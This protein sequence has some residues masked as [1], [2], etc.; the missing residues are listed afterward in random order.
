MSRPLASVV[1]PT[2]DR[3]AVLARTLEALAAQEHAEGLFD[4]V[5]AVNAS[6]DDTLEYLEA[7][8]WPFKLRV[9]VLDRPGAALARNE[10]AR[11][12]VA[13]L[14]IFLDDDIQPCP[15]FVRAHLDAHGTTLPALDASPVVGIGYLPTHLQP[16]Q[17]RFAITLRGWWEAMFDRMREPGHRFSWMD[18]LSGNCSVGRRSFTAV[19]GFETSLRCHEDYELGYRLIE[20][21]CRFVFVEDAA[22]WHADETR[23]ERACRRKREEG[24]ADAWI[25][26]HHPELR[27]GLPMSRPATVRQRLSRWLAFTWPSA[28]DVGARV[29]LHLLPVLEKTGAT[30]AWLR[31]LYAVFG[32]WYERGLADALGERA[33]LK[34][35]LEGAWQE[36]RVCDLGPDVDLAEGLDRAVAFLDRERPDA[37]RIVV[38]QMS[39]AR[40]PWVPGTE[41]LAGRHLLPLL[42]RFYHRPVVEKL[43]ESGTLTVAQLLNSRGPAGEVAAPVGSAR[44]H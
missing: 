32:Y 29:F 34:R 5:V 21:G 20:H 9:V 2:R 31:V 17:D 16:E 15:R 7:A 18:L 19:G 22:G 26:E 35:V 11:A 41:R 42:T 39:I 6:T 4:V 1:I 33:R 12:S 10:G 38:G 14:I 24:I 44:V 28:G 36:P 13:P 43:L 8:R 23:V 3:R 37:V 25:A 27:T 30:M 40:V